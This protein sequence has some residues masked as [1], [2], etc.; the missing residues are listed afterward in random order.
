MACDLLLGRALASRH[1]AQL[2]RDTALEGMR[3]GTRAYWQ[4]RIRECFLRTK[5]QKYFDEA[6]RLR[7]ALQ[8]LQDKVTQP[9]E[10]EFKSQRTGQKA[11]DMNEQQQGNK[12][13]QPRAQPPPAEIQPHH[14]ETQPQP[15]YMS[16]RLTKRQKAQARER[17][18]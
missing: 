10:L 2:Q 17:E 8:K 9:D 4:D 1:K 12:E 7:T 14:A 13:V 15:A 16:P 3:W 18:R 6:A 11:A 5:S